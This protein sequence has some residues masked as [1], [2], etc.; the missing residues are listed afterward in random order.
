MVRVRACVRGENNSP[1]LP[2]E[3][4]TANKKG[5][6][7]QRKGR[8]FTAAAAAG[9]KQR[10]VKIMPQHQIKAGNLWHGR[11]KYILFWPAKNG[12]RRRINI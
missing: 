3:W 2:A 5:K 10:I 11:K 12:A 8:G 9:A 7:V 4:H 6:L 1:E